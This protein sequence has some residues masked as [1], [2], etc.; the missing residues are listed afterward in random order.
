MATA[1]FSRRDAIGTNMRDMW[2][3]EIGVLFFQGN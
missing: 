3:S 2:A 1:S